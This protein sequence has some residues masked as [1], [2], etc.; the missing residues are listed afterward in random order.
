MSQIQTIN[1]E[2]PSLLAPKLRNTLAR[3]QAMQW[4]VSDPTQSDGGAPKAP[5]NARGQLLSP[6]S[7]DGWLSFLVAGAALGSGVFQSFGVRLDG[8]GIIGIDLD[9]YA[10][11]SAEFPKLGQI[12]G[13]ALERGAY[14]EKSPSGTGLRAFVFGKLPTSGVRKSKYG[15]ELYADNR[16]LRVTGW[17]HRQ[18]SE[19]TADQMLIDDLLTLIGVSDAPER[20]AL[21]DQAVPADDGLVEKVA[22]KVRER[23]PALWSG[24]LAI[25]CDSAGVKYGPSE[26]DMVLCSVIKNAGIDAGAPISVMPDLIGRVMAQ[27]GLARALHG[28]GTEKWLE[29]ADYRERTIAAVCADLE[30]SPAVLKREAGVNPN[31]AGDIA[32]AER[33]AQAHRGKL[34]WVPEMST[35]LQWTSPCW[36][37]CSCGEEIQAAKSV[38]FGLVDEARQVMANDQERGTTMMRAAMAAQKDARIRAM[39]SLARAEPGM[40]ASVTELDADS[41]LLGVQNGVVNLKTGELL[42]AKPEQLI[43]K[44]CAASYNPNAACPTWLKFLH[45]VFLGDSELTAYVQRAVGYTLTGSNTEET[46]FVCYGHGSNGKSLLHNVISR[47]MADYAKGAPADI[48]VQKQGVNPGAASP[49]LA[50]LAGC[51]MLGINETGTGD[52]LDEQALKTLAGREAITARPLYGSYFTFSPAFTPWL[53]TNHKPVITGTDHAVWRRLALIPFKRQFSGAERDNGLEAKLWAERDAIL[54]WAVAGAVE[55][56]RNGLQACATI[57]QEV[58]AYRRESDLLGQYLGEA[59]KPD[60]AVRVVQGLLYAGWAAWCAENGVRPTSKASFTR[61]LAELGHSTLRSH[62]HSYYTGLAM[63]TTGLIPPPLA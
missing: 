16:Y 5:R 43:S 33:F 13:A 4:A 35:W 45:E 53:R 23:D 32:L 54:A 24:D 9:H 37:A 57:T 42:E 17:K 19:I 7:G 12:I 44:Q 36:G 47:I 55:W 52:R 34:L 6:A 18:S 40:T 56:S 38:L 48:L 31:A 50:M 49:A 3:L 46:L 41:H 10:E 29:R 26:A 21:S 61:R 22:A 62:G 15:V 20:Q 60:P 2:L 58:Q 14:V 63:D 39:L 8:M 51:R 28:D 1:N 11:K 59:T 25:A 30:A 27:S